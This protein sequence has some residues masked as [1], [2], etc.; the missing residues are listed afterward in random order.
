M[1][2]EIRSLAATLGVAD[3]VR[4]LGVRSDAPAL[5]NAADCYLLSSA[6]EVMPLVLQEAGASELPVVATQVGGNAEVVRDGSSGFLVAPQDDG[7]LAAG[8]RRMMA[9]SNDERSA[10]G[11]AGREFI[12]GRFDMERVLDQWE[13][14]YEELLAAR[15]N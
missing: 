4:L 11:R 8:M 6:W 1:E 7:A 12:A 2:S 13:S 15:S 3:R 5:M 9:L 10:M 14:I